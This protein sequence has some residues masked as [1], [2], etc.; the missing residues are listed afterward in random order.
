MALMPHPIPPSD[1]I[2]SL[3]F[4]RA[5]PTSA[6]CTAPLT[7]LFWPHNCRCF[8]LSSQLTIPI[9]CISVAAVSSAVSCLSSNGL[10]QNRHRYCSWSLI[11]L[12]SKVQGTT[13]PFKHPSKGLGLVTHLLLEMDEHSISGRFRY[14]LQV[15]TNLIF[16]TRFR[17]LQFA[18][19]KVKKLTS[20]LY[21]SRQHTVQVS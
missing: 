16:I 12:Y 18:S 4:V 14:N 9:P 2:H 15:S 21:T 13:L 10:P 20:L 3:P 5:F 6:K 1:E 17:I 7:A 8:P 19:P 11:L